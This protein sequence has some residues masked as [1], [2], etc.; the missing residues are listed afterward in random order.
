MFHWPIPVTNYL[1]SSEEI[2]AL[3]MNAIFPSANYPY[4]EKMKKSHYE[5]EKNYYKLNSQNSSIG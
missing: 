5:K 2:N 4:T 3:P 1:A